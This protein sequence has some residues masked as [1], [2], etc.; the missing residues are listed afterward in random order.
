[1]SAKTLRLCS[2][3][4]SLPDKTEKHSHLDGQI[5]VNG[6]S[7]LKG[8]YEACTRGMK[9]WKCPTRQIPPTPSQES[10]LLQF[11]LRHTTA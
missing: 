8:F 2:D 6:M 11:T 7:K 3:Y 5:S 4:H 9:I 10:Q 1:M